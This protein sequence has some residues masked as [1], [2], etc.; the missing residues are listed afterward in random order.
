MRRDKEAFVFAKVVR[1]INALGNVHRNRGSS[2][3]AVNKGGI[4]VK[5]GVNS[6]VSAGNI[7]L[8]MAGLRGSTFS[9]SIVPRALR[10]S[11]LNNLRV[12]NHIGLRQTLRLS[13]HLNKRVI[14]NR[15]SNAKSV[16]RCHGSSGTI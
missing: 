10:H 9:T 16:G 3:I 2:I 7:Y 11:G 5:A 12:N 8:A 15:V 13:A 1:R 6:D 14:D 4:L